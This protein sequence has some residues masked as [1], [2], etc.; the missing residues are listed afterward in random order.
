MANVPQTLWLFP[1][2]GLTQGG[3]V[4]VL[5]LDEAQ[6]KLLSSNQAFQLKK[7][8]L[9]DQLF[10]KLSHK[11]ATQAVTQRVAQD[12]ITKL[13]RQ[14][15][16]QQRGARVRWSASFCSC[17]AVAVFAS[18]RTCGQQGGGGRLRRRMLA[19]QVRTDVRRRG[20]AR[21]LG[22]SHACLAC[23]FKNLLSYLFQNI[24]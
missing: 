23:V 15:R 7:N 16:K 13:T 2:Q 18:W 22:G 8:A 9:K 14:E 6:R 11:A 1:T 5:H 24:L 17:F 20:C 19:T 4:I 3:S 12:Y 10:V 21:F